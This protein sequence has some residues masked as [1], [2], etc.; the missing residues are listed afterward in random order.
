MVTNRTD[1]ALLKEFLGQVEDLL[2]FAYKHRSEVMPKH[3]HGPLEA[4]WP[5]FQRRMGI[6]KDQFTSL[7]PEQLSGLIERGLTGKELGLKLAG[8]AAPYEMFKSVRDTETKREPEQTR[9]RRRLRGLIPLIISSARKVVRRFGGL[10]HRDEEESLREEE[11][12]KPKW[13]RW[14][15]KA[16]KWANIIIGSIPEILFPM[17]D[18]VEEVKLVV[19]RGVEDGSDFKFTEPRGIFPGYREGRP[20]QRTSDDAAEGQSRSPSIRTS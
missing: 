10:L 14:L 15:L 9:K 12:K 13:V 8:F 19:E 16:L 2:E 1:A 5:E 6:L 4:A 18:A 11:G 20:P 7:T 3:L 17:K